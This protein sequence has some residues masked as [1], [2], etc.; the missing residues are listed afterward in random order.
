MTRGTDQAKRA[1]VAAAHHVGDGLDGRAG[2]QARGQ[3]AVGQ[4]PGVGIERAAP[5]RFQCVDLVQ[6]FRFM[7]AQQLLPGRLS[8]VTGWASVLISRSLQMT[9][10][11]LQPFGTLGVARWNEMIEHST[12]RDTN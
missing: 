5:L 3:G 12:I 11:R 7:R 10:D 6:V 8:Y 4:Y 9:Q 1:A 2:G